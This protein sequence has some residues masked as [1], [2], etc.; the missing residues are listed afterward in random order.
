MKDLYFFLMLLVEK[1]GE[2][3]CF[4]DPE[5]TSRQTHFLFHLLLSI[6]SVFSV[7]YMN[8][9]VPDN[10]STFCALRSMIFNFQF[11]CVSFF[12]SSYLTLASSGFYGHLM[13]E[14]A[15]SL[16]WAI[17]HILS[18]KDQAGGN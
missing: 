9:Y 1:Q 13:H 18:F 2:L 10:I 16:L 15:Q 8:G 17:F 11:V 4:S 12:F 3:L 5:V 14:V 6:M 7:N